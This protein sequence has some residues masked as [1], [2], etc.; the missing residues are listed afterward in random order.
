MPAMA[1]SAIMNAMLLI[2]CS[3][4]TWTSAPSSSLSVKGMLTGESTVETR[5]DASA[6]ERSPSYMP[7]HMKHTTPTG[8]QYSSVTPVTRLGFPLNSTLAMR[9]ATTGIAIMLTP[10]MHS[11]SLGWRNCTATLLKSLFRDPWNVRSANIAGT[12]GLARPN[13][14]GNSTPRITHAGAMNDMCEPI[15]LPNLVHLSM[16]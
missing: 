14:S 7:H 3:T 12:A 6:S 11:T 10:R 9:C 13:T 2:I 5:I 15:A 4:S 8:T 1:G 16:Q